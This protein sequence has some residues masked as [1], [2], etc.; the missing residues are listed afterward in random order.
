MS[1]MISMF[2][3]TLPVF[4]ATVR[5]KGY[6]LNFGGCLKDTGVMLALSCMY[7]GAP[8]RVPEVDG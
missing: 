3:G 5:R 6:G 4:K 2:E 8:R 1:E 7:L